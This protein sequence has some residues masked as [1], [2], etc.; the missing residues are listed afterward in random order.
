MWH[1]EKGLDF[2]VTGKDKIPGELGFRW[3]H[4]QVLL[5]LGRDTAFYN[6]LPPGLKSFCH[7][8]MCLQKHF[9]L[10]PRAS[11]AGLVCKELLTGKNWV[12]QSRA[13]KG[14]NE[15]KDSSPWCRIYVR[16]SMG[17]IVKLRKLRTREWSEKK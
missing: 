1:R 12:A 6:N 4:T 8:R 11:Y 14:S 16:R 2:P 3:K 17:W 15:G 13:Q 10:L 5:S 9:P 7:Q